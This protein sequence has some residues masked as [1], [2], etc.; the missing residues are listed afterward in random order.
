MSVRRIEAPLSTTAWQIDDPAGRVTRALARDVSL[1]ARP[2][3][4]AA[5]FACRSRHAAVPGVMA[6]AGGE[7]EW[8]FVPDAAWTAGDYAIEVLPVLEDPGGQPHR[9]RLREHRPA[10]DTRAAPVRLPFTVR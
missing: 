2:R 4:A 6:S 9:P 10:D 3:P 5:R 7:T 1:G 8:R